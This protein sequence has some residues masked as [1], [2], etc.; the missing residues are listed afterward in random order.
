M[1]TVK[2]DTVVVEEKE[3][4]AFSVKQIAKLSDKITDC[5]FR[6]NRDWKQRVVRLI[7]DMNLENRRE[8]IARANLGV[9]GVNIIVSG[10]QNRGGHRR[11]RGERSCKYIVKFARRR[12]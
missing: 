2:A 8:I 11:I 1:L 12:C 4:E 7:V 3:K 9:K 10:L 6:S 5:D